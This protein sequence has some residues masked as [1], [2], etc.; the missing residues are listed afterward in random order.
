[1]QWPSIYE[2]PAAV[3]KV[4]ANELSQLSFNERERVYHDIHAVSE[5]RVQ[6][7]DDLL[8]Q[9]LEK[10]EIEISNL[11]SKDR[12]TILQEGRIPTTCKIKHYVSSFCELSLLIVG[13]QLHESRTSLKPSLNF[14]GNRSL[15]KIYD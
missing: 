6:E 14:L 10:L 7:T 9:S 1:M 3:D 13:L 5:G 8:A 2:D 4:L 12:P 11:G 15:L